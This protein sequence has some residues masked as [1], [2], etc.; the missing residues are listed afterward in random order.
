LCDNL[1]RAKI[2]LAN[3]VAACF[4]LAGLATDPDYSTYVRITKI[5][6]SLIARAVKTELL[7]EE[8]RI[9]AAAATVAE[10]SGQ[11]SALAARGQWKHRSY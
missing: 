11:G 1:A 7:L 4:M 6:K 3:H 5:D 2:E 8:R 10:S 9:D